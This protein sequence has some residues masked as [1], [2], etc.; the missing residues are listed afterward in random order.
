MCSLCAVNVD[1]WLS[2]TIGTVAILQREPVV[3]TINGVAATAQ[4]LHGAINQL[5]N[6]LGDLRTLIRTLIISDIYENRPGIFST[7]PQQ[8][9]LLNEVI[10]TLVVFDSAVTTNA[11]GQTDVALTV[12][13]TT[14]NVVY[15]VTLQFMDTGQIFV[16]AVTKNAVRGPEG[17]GVKKNYKRRRGSSGGSSPAPP[18][19]EDSDDD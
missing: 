12:S 16:G 5:Q 10:D 15:F 11:P 19:N 4:S 13:I 7:I 14:N 2:T 3:V 8:S 18:P 6:N 1:D 17:S 9:L